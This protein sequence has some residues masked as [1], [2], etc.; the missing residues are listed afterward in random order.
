[1]IGTEVSF[2]IEYLTRIDVDDEKLIFTIPVHSNNSQIMKDI[3]V[4]VKVIGTSAFEGCSGITSIL[5]PNS[6]TTLDKDFFKCCLKIEKLNIPSSIITFN[7][8]WFNNCLSLKTVI[9]SDQIHHYD[10]FIFKYC[11]LL[12]DITINSEWKFVNDRLFRKNNRCFTRWCCI[13]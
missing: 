6:L 10:N 8:N 3:P 2:T 11:F 5:L 12:E 13:N 4:S 1:M 9:L 7:N